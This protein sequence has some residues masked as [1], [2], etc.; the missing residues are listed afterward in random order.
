M[1]F[2][3]SMH[4]LCKELFPINRSLTGNG[5]RETLRILQRE[6]PELNILEVPS[7]TTCFDW[8]VPNEWNCKEAYI[9][10]PDG[11][12]ICDYSKNNL[13]LLGY[14]TPVNKTLTLEELNDFLYDL[15]EL[16]DAIPYMTSYYKERW[17]FCIA[18]NE[19]KKL[20]QGDY[21]VY[22]NSTL[23]KGNLT[24]GELLIEGDT[25]E[26]IFFSTYVCHPSMGNNEL[27]GPAVVTYLAKYI[28]SLPNR[29]YSYRIIFIPETIGAIM[30]LSK[31]LKEM[32]KNIVA[33][34]NVSCVGDNNIYS[35]LPSR[36]GNTLADKVA[37]HVMNHKIID[38]KSYTFLDR[39][40]DERQYCSVNVDLPVCC[41]MRSKY[42]EYKEYHTSLDD[43]D[44][45][46]PEGLNGAYEVYV[47]V[48]NV[49]EQNH[50]YLLTTFCEPQLG[51]RGLYPTLSTT[52]TKEKV[53]DMMNFL[54][55][56]DGKTD[57]IDIANKINLPVW[58]LYDIIKKFLDNGLIVIS[59]ISNTKLS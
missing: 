37:T 52:G 46:S 13:H 8:T 14:S 5:V 31:N 20:K 50:K 4:D 38:Y 21:K 33:G 27:S 29:K 10:D 19:R 3:V 51:K 17:G 23:E 12:K 53:K 9:I 34:F 45:I 54:A 48:I 35:F 22:I 58:N 2:G 32:K 26:E 16:P 56:C 57:L 55:Y 1:N 28:N 47:E 25:K 18:H 40:S 49:L 59:P 39:A 41:I 44:Y 30:Y 36:E 42:G 43:L 24:Y 6:V 15:P 11:H 7:G